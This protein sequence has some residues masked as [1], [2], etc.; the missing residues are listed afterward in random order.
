VLDIGGGGTGI[1]GGGAFSPMMAE[2]YN[3][4][5]LS[6]AD[7]AADGAG[8]AALGVGGLMKLVELGGG[9]PAGAGGGMLVGAG[10]P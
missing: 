7:V 1:G 3:I 9:R 10:D 5:L 8:G 4:A 6:R 2:L